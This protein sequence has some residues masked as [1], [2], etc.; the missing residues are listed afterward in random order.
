[1]VTTG[2]TV[3][4]SHWIAGWLSGQLCVRARKG[5][6]TSKENMKREKETDR[7]RVYIEGGNIEG[8]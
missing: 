2:C 4:T 1:M 6:G 8:L 7:L 5:N 3:L